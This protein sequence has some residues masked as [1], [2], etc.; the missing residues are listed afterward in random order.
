MSYRPLVLPDAEPPRNDQAQQA[1]STIRAGSALFEE[2][3]GLVAGGLPIPTEQTVLT[4]SAVYAC[5]N[6]IAAGGSARP[7]PAPPWSGWRSSAGR[8]ADRHPAD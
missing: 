5:V 8:R 7:R 4:I 1:S 3:T 6:I 2:L